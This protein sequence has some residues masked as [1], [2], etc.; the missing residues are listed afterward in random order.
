MRDLIEVGRAKIKNRFMNASGCFGYGVE[1]NKIMDLEKLGAIV[2]K[3]I[4]SKPWPGNSGVRIAETPAGMLN[5]IGLENPGVDYFLENYLPFL[6]TKDLSVVVNV[7]GHT[8]DEYGEVAKK[9]TDSGVCALEINISCPNVKAGGISMG[10]SPDIAYEVVK[11]VR[12]ETK[13]PLWV[14]LSPNVTDIVEIAV[15]VEEAGADALTLINTLTG[16]VIDTK[17]KKPLLG[18]IT[19]GLS[20]PA[21]KPIAIRMVYQV[22][23]N[24]KIPV[25]GV[26]G[27]TCLEDA[28]EFFMAGASAVQVGSGLFKEPNLLERLP[29]EFETY[30]NKESLSAEELIGI[31]RRNLNA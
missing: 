26:G 21:I 30:L 28:L 22:T 4:S 7:I 15:A 20:G 12:S 31:A 16:M 13:L 6:Q 27:I 11:T 8:I 18:N 1:F 29:E 19:G 5:C 9:L 17:T 10:T 23:G 24:V 3:G 2:V 14:K 25:I